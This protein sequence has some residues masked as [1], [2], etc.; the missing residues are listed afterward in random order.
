MAFEAVDFELSTDTGID[1]KLVV[2]THKEE[3]YLLTDW[4]RSQLLTHL[5][6]REK[7]FQHVTLEQQAEELTKRVPTFRKH[8]LRRMTSAD[9]SLKILRGLV[10]KEYADIPDID[11]MAAMRELAP[12]GKCLRSYSDKTDRAL[13]VFL[14][15]DQETVGLT[16]VFQGHPGVI[17][18]NSEVGYTS[19][20]VI[21]F[22]LV[23]AVDGRYRPVVLR[24]ETLL[25]RVHRGTVADLRKDFD[26]ALQKLST[27]FEDMKT[28]LQALSRIRFASEDEAIERMSKEL[29]TLNVTK[30]AL[31]DYSRA[32]KALSHPTHTGLTVLQTVIQTNRACTT[33]TQYDEA[34]LAGALLLRFI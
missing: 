30:G 22:I 31:Q 3:R 14:V 4:A 7:W 12:D 17:F 18:K 33:D 29:K 10:S 6:T 28:R 25:R 34:E 20:W 23:K 26:E 32:Y 9:P 2:L 8:R 27:V 11:M 21:P 16:G 1:E 24:S 19:L 13:Y 15:R 5:G